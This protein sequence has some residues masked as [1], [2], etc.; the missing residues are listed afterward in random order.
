MRYFGGKT[1][2]SLT[3]R[4]IAWICVALAAI[5]FAIVVFSLEVGA[6]PISASDVVLT[7]FRG[8]IGH[9][10]SIAPSDRLVV[11]G[12][13]LPRIA[14]GILVGAALSVSGASFQALLRHPLADP[15][16]LGVSSGAACGAIGR[17]AWF[18]RQTWTMKLLAWAAGFVTMAAVC[19]V[20]RR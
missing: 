3:P 13:R 2:R 11:F 9:W 12:L 17:L 6:F 4:R 20:G 5:L 8:A 7:L 16:V 14:L 1:M 10:N 18:P 15:Y 19:F